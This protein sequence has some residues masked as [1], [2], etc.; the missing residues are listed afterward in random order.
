MFDGLIASGTVPKGVASLEA[1]KRMVFND[2]LDAAVAAF[3]MAAVIVILFESTRMW[4]RI[5]SGRAPATST[6][7]SFT[8]TRDFAVDAIAG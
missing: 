8:P 4:L 1:A 6:E 7:V 5:L 2:R 3:F